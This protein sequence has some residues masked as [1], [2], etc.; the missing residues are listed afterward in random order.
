VEKPTALFYDN[1]ND[2]FTTE[3]VDISTLERAIPQSSK[4]II[5]DYSPTGIGVNYERIKENPRNVLIQQEVHRFYSNLLL[6]LTNY[7]FPPN[8]ENYINSNLGIASISFN[9]IPIY[10]FIFGHY[11]FLCEALSYTSFGND[12]IP[13]LTYLRNIFYK[14]K[15]DDLEE[16]DKQNLIKSFEYFDKVYFSNDNNRAGFYYISK[17]D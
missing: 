4:S 9:T 13:T 2:E 5:K 10:S 11:N 6:L 1:E 17:K 12:F 7:N 14:G 16:F 8:I 3:K 15:I